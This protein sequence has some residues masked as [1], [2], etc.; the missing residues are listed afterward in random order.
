MKNDSWTDV[1]IKFDDG[2]PLMSLLDSNALTE[3][4]KVLSF[5][6]EKYD[7][8]NWRKGITYSRLIDAALRHMIAF[9]GGEDLDPESN[10]SHVAHAS[11][12]LMFLLWMIENRCDLDDRYD[13]DQAYLDRIE[14]QLKREM[15]AIEKK[16][17]K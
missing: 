2:K 12:C 8:H 15:D 9:N 7:R 3:M 4:A 17:Q 5:G 13:D 6:A 16:S 10:L 11:C 1:G 14:E